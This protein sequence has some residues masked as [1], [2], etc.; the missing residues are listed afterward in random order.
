M[1]TDARSAVSP[2]AP[3]AC[4]APPAKLGYAEYCLYPN[5]G[6]R[7]EI[8]DGD[9]YVNPAP[10]TYHQ[11]VSRRLQYQLYTQIELA[12]R[13]VVYNAPVDVQLSDHDIVQPDLVVVIA[14]RI[15]MITPTKI[16]GVPDLLVE[17]LSPSTA[18]HD[19]TLKKQ[20]YERVGVA[21]Y[22]IADPDNH[23][24][25]QFVLVNGRYE[26]RSAGDDVR[27]SFLDGVT[28]RLADVW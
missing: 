7:H 22:W 8:I 21:E 19:A 2:T 3:P 6:R 20:L 5:D 17:I 23:T 16:K 25:C 27:L 18:S 28:V 24:L 10:S 9:H 11:T 4:P 1:A 26:Q 12:G 15:Q 13:G 14:P